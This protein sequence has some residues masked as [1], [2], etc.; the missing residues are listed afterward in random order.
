LWKNTEYSGTDWGII[1]NQR[2]GYNVD[3]D[4]LYASVPATEYTTDVADILSNGIKVRHDLGNMNESNDVI[5]FMAF[6]ES[7]FKTSNAR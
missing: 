6:A 7:P 5:I 2:E 4:P 3:N 1:D